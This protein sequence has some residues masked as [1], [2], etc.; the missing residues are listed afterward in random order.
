MTTDNCPISTKGLQALRD[1]IE[2]RDVDR[3]VREVQRE[4]GLIEQRLNAA[5][6]AVY[7]GER[8]SS[9]QFEPVTE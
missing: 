2:Q 6:G 9:L 5:F 7:T 1:L 8:V 4:Q 3:L